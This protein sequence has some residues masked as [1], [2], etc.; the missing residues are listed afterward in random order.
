HYLTVPY[1]ANASFLVC[2]DRLL[3]ER[4]RAKSAPEWNTQLQ[5]LYDVEQ[6][7]LEEFV[8][9]QNAW[10]NEKRKSDGQW[11]KEWAYAEKDASDSNKSASNPQAYRG[12]LR[13]ATWE[14]LIL[15]CC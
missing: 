4:L 7:A 2:N 12:K 15:L 14:E 10:T 3:A 6:K 11:H 9:I 8:C 5:R 1:N 13:I